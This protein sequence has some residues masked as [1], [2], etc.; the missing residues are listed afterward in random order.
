ME[1]EGRGGGG[2][3]GGARGVEGGGTGCAVGVEATTIG[4]GGGEGARAG[5]GGLVRP[6]EGP[7]AKNPSYHRRASSP[8]RMRSFASRVEGDVDLV[9][10]RPTSLTKRGAR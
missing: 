6:D 3:E 1:L 7:L 10:V 2:G 9:L 8:L 4:L 5:G